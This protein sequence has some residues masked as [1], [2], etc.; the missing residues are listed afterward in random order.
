MEII[1]KLQEHIT[2]QNIDYI[3]ELV[4][5]I[6]E[7]K[8][9]SIDDLK[10]YEN[11]YNNVDSSNLYNDVIYNYIKEIDDNPYEYEGRLYDDIQTLKQERKMMN[12]DIIEDKIF[13][14]IKYF[15]MTNR[16]NPFPYI[17]YELI[18]NNKF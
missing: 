7:E 9:E 11:K 1:K 2:D 5:I 8:I 4:D 13:H 6:I 12:S 18:T 15:K 14:L 16:E 3:E 17:T 10:V